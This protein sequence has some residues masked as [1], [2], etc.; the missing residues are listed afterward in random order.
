MVD[1]FMIDM[2]SFDKLWRPF[3]SLKLTNIARNYNSSTKLVY[4]MYKL[5][6]FAMLTRFCK[7]V[8]MLP[9]IG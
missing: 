4:E 7:W 6:L 3:Q 5:N 1:S 2:D 9:H 8:A